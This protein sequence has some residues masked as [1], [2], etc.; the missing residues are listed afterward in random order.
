MRNINCVSRMNPDCTRIW[1][2]VALPSVRD[3]PAN[4]DRVGEV[5]DL[6]FDLCRACC[7]QAAG[8]WPPRSPSCCDAAFGRPGSVLGS[9]PSVNKPGFAYAVLVIQM[10]WMRSSREPSVSG[11]PVPGFASSACAKK[12]LDSP[13]EFIE[14]DVGKPL[15]NEMIDEIVQSPSTAAPTPLCAHRLPSPNG[16]SI[17]G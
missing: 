2:N 5:Q 6:E 13:F 12:A 17:D 1:P 9:V 14:I 10:S 8:P 3:R 16:S 11:S 4:L 7:H 15:S